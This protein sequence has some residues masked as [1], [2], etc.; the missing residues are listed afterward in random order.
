MISTQMILSLPW[1]SLV[2]TLIR[3]ASGNRMMNSTMK[4]VRRMPPAK[5]DRKD[6]VPIF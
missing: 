1:N 3:A 4:R 6:M 5:I 2:R